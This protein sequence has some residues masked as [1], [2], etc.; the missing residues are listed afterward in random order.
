MFWNQR[1]LRVV[2]A[3]ALTVALAGPVTSARAAGLPRA[4]HSGGKS[5][6]IAASVLSWVRSVLSDGIFT[7]T[8]ACNDRGAGLDPNGGCGTSGAG[9]SGDPNNPPGH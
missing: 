1:S 2:A 4:G 5:P 9:S 8:A 7:R 3:L 6:S